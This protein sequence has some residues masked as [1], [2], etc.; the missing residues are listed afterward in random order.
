MMIE[1][2]SKLK[3]LVHKWKIGKLEKHAH[4]ELWEEDYELID[5][6]GLFQEYLEMG[7]LSVTLSLTYVQNI[8]IF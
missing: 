2:R 5:N 7:Q 1:L 6:E 8:L 4:K 3:G